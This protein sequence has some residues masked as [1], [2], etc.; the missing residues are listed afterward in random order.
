MQWH[1]LA[2]ACCRICTELLA[3]TVLVVGVA[4]EVMEAVEMAVAG[5]VKADGTEDVA[6]AMAGTV[7][8]TEAG[9]EAADGTEDMA[10]EAGEAAVMVEAGTVD[11]TADVIDGEEVDA[12]GGMIGVGV[13]D[14][15]EV[16][17]G[18]VDGAVCLG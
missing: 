9:A 4:V 8:E 14:G 7:E 12:D 16:E 15:K 10:V 13:E 18:A 6:E 3:G 1:S 2:L 11:V 17:A 5:E